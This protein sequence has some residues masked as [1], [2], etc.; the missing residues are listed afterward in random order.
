MF[1]V[2]CKP[3][4]YLFQLSLQKGVFLDHLK[5]AKVTAINKAGDSNDISNYKLMS[6]LPCFSKVL[7]SV[8]YN[9][10]YKYL[11]ENNIIY[12]KQFGFQRGYSSNDAI[13]KLVNKMFD[14]FEKEQFSLKVFID[15]SKVFDTVDHFVLLKKL[16]H[17]GIT[18]KSLAWFESNLTNRKRH[19]HT[20]ENR[21]TDL[22]YITCAVHQESAAFLDH[23]CFYYM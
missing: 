9:R 11:K 14:S 3:L 22:K 16:N 21:K 5:T 20:G 8:M 10:L 1:W 12:K 6:I 4:I 15:L 19:I 18:E 2:L 13:A 23:F 7:E 17:Y